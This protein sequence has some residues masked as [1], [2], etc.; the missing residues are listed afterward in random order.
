MEHIA[1]RADVDLR[2]AAEAALRVA[3]GHGASQIQVFADHGLL[4]LTGEVSTEAERCAARAAMRSVSGVHSVVD[5]LIFR[6]VGIYRG[7]DNDIARASQVALAKATDIPPDAIVA[8]V[9]HRVVS[10]SGDVTF[11]SERLAAERAITYVRGVA[12]IENLIRV[13]EDLDDAQSL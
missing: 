5:E 6:G 2:L 9:R 1:N 11:F 3:L 7:S 13:S 10:L 4:T 8:E 12:K